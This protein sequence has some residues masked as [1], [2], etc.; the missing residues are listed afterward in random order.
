[1]RYFNIFEGLPDGLSKFEDD[2]GSIIDIFYKKEINH[3]NQIVSNPNVIRGNHKHNHT[4]QH[5]LITSGSLEYWY[6]NDDMPESDFHKAKTGDL[7][8]SEPGEIHALKIGPSGCTFITFSEGI[9]GGD[10]YESDTIRVASI[11]TN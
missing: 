9:R 11:I 3:V 8:T 2:R 7:L 5:I 1:M 6:Q 10:D 4:T